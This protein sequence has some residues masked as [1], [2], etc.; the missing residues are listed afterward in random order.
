MYKFYTQLKYKATISIFEF[1]PSVDLVPVLCI[2]ETSKQYTLRN[3]KDKEME[4]KGFHKLAGINLSYSLSKG[5]GLAYDNGDLI[6]GNINNINS[7]LGIKLSYSLVLDGKIDI[8]G[9]EG[10]DNFNYKYP[11]TLIG[12]RA[13]GTVILC[14]VD[15]RHKKSRGITAQES[16]Q[17]MID[18]GCIT[19]INA[20]GQGYSQMIYKDKIINDY[21]YP[22]T[23]A[24]NNGLIVY[25]KDKI[26]T[27]PIK[28]Y[29]I[30]ISWSKGDYVYI[31]QRLLKSKGYK[32]NLNGVFDPLTYNSVRSFQKQNAL[33][34]DGIVGEVVWAKLLQ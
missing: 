29:P 24:I 3:I 13:D 14:S 30:L 4:R 1:E 19:A 8:Q 11:R 9:E 25:S 5:F 23:R 20:N 16:A 28:D 32:I 10:I 21:P 18:L 27:E 7:S 2:S 15:G 31:L 34:E 22:Y 6:I 17:I 12:K 26:S 33:I